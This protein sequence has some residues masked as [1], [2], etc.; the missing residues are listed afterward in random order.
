MEIATL[1]RENNKTKITILDAEEVQK[2][3]TAFEAETAKAEAEK[4]KK[5]EK[6]WELN[7]IVFCL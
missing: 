6:K 2:Y 1:T 7:K 4:K 5:E 3:I